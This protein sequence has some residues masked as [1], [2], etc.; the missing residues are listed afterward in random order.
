MHKFKYCSYPT[1]KHFNEDYIYVSISIGKSSL[2]HMEGLK[3]VFYLN[4]LKV[5]LELLNPNHK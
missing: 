3:K 2:P 4:L 1:I 5:N